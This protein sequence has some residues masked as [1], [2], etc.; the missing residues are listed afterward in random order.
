MIKFLKKNPKTSEA[1][2]SEFEEQFDQHLPEEYRT[3]IL[4]TNGGVMSNYTY[5]TY[6]DEEFDEDVHV[7]IR[8]FFGFDTAEKSFDLV[9][10]EIKSEN[11]I[12]RVEIEYWIQNLIAIARI[13][14][15]HG[16]IVISTSG[17]N[18][19][20]VYVMADELPTFEFAQKLG[21]NFKDFLAKIKFEDSNEQ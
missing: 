3:F 21:E 20:M 9:T 13:D 4:S 17:D 8:E 19:G 16:Y 18:K 7:Y 11:R 10:K 12:L 6:E 2:I 15:G 14:D 5:V 1:I